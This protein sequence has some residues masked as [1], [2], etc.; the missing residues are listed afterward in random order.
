MVDVPEVSTAVVTGAASGMGRST[1]A[2][3]LKEGWDVIALDRVA[4][5]FVVAGRAVRTV[6]V[7]VTRRDEVRD[8]IAESLTSSG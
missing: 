1:A 2:V 8:A 3:L 5:E 7:D 4:T 6:E